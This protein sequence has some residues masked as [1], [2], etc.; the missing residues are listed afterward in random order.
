MNARQ[1]RYHKEMAE[2]L[3]ALTGRSIDK[4]IAIVENPKLLR[5]VARLERQMTG[6]IRARML[7]AIVRRQGELE[8]LQLQTC[9][10]C[11]CTERHGCPGGCS[12]TSLDTCSQCLEP[13]T[14]R[15]GTCVRGFVDPES[16][17]DCPENGKT[18]TA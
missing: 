17:Y 15:R 11:G 2:S 9:I 7:R 10:H 5:R 18:C 3:V 12:W 8:R 14:A 16:C 6:R 13:S 1:R 4:A